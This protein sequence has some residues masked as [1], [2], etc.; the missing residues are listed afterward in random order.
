MKL[1]FVRVV[2]S[3]EEKLRILREGWG[4]KAVSCFHLVGLGSQEKESFEFWRN[5]KVSRSFKI[6]AVSVKVFSSNFDRRL[7]SSSKVPLVRVSV[8]TTG[9]PKF[10]IERKGFKL[11][12]AFIN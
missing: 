3:W 9:E 7:G 8:S 12:Q 2:V 5:I 10:C 4:I 6:P 11:F 1:H